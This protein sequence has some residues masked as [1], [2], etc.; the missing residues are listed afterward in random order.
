[1]NHATS[2]RCGMVEVIQTEH[3]NVMHFH[4]SPCHPTLGRLFSVVE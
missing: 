4:P 1:M 3:E 2:D